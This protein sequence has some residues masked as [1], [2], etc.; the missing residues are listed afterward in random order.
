MSGSTTLYFRQELLKVFFT[1]DVYVQQYN[2]LALCVCTKPPVLNASASQLNEP[3]GN[4]YNR[5]PIL[6]NNASWVITGFGEIANAN[7]LTFSAPTGDWGMIGGW[8][9]VT[10][11]GSDVSVAATGVLAR[12]QR[13]L[14]GN[15]PTLPA[16]GLILGL[17]D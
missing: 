12:P 5:L 14:S 2:S 6:L 7:P 8:A 4:G 10:S 9:L 3:V 15:A 17:F 1:R 11:G 13:V 16:Q